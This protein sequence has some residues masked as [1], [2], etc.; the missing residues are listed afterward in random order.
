[1][2]KRYWIP[3][4]VVA[5]LV[6][7]YFLGPPPPEPVFDPTPV[8][9]PAAPAALEAYVAEK[10]AKWPLRDDNQAR[11]RWHD[12]RRQRTEYAFVYLHGFAG[13]YRDGY[14]FNVAVADTFAANL[15]LA[16]YAGH[17]L[18]PPHSMVTFTPEAAWEDAKE[19][20]A[21]GKRLGEKVVVLSTSTGGTLA[22]LLAV[23]FPDDV[24]ALV[25]IGPNYQ[26]DIPGTWMLNSNWGYELSHLVSLGNYR[27]ISYDQPGADQYWDTMYVAEALLEL[28]VMVGNAMV[29]ETFRR[30][31]TPVLT[32]YYHKD[33]FNEDE[34]VEVSVYPDAHAAFASPPDQTAL[35]ALPTPG[36]HF[37]GSDIMSDD[38]DTTVT[39]AVDYLRKLEAGPR[40]RAS[41][42]TPASG[43]R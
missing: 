11:I 33:D 40:L 26:D 39:T 12:D 13:S 35:V 5:L 37:C 6:V 25:S 14:P 19:A 16:R 32:M 2:K 41:S 34:R 28:Q 24:H 22:T 20:L 4:L 21:I 43:G 38:V 1:M 3:A 29:E 36:T 42:G 15:Y 18:R 9:V 8:T 27:E 17:G 10:E 7:T 30:V 23:H 31:R